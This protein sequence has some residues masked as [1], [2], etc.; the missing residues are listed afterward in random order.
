[1]YNPQK[2]KIFLLSS[3]VEL[4]IAKEKRKKKK[5]RKKPPKLTTN[6]TVH[7]F[8]GIKVVSS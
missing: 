5:E 7:L 6:A 1:M 8:L 2:S 3:D 4:F